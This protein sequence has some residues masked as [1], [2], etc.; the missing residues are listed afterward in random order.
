[1]YLQSLQAWVLEL[2]YGLDPGGSYPHWSSDP[3]ENKP[4]SFGVIFKYSI[5]Y[6]KSQKAN[7]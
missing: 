4:L 6:G 2:S 1:M 5:I 7:L 3:E